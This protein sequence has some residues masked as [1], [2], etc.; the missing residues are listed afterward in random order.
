MLTLTPSF[1]CY[2]LIK[3]KTG[4]SPTQFVAQYQE[5]P[6]SLTPLEVATIVWAAQHETMESKVEHTP[7]HYGNLMI[8]THYNKCY[9]Q[10]AVWLFSSLVGW[11]K[12]AETSDETPEEKKS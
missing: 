8:Q 1:A 3:E 5:D 10:V 7:E 12:T 6:F 2:Q 4:K 11:D 9:E